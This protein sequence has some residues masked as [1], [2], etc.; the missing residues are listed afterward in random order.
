MQPYPK[1][2]L[3]VANQSLT[4]QADHVGQGWPTHL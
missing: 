3:I 4:G 2:R 1:W